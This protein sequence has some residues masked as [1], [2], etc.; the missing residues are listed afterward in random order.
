MVDNAIDD[1]LALL[2]ADMKQID[3]LQQKC[4][5]EAA[6][7]T[8]NKRI[9]RRLTYVF[10]GAAIGVGALLTFVPQLDFVSQELRAVWLNALG[11]VSMATGVGIA[12][13]EKYVD[14]DRQRQRA[15][16]L[17]THVAEMGNGESAAKAERSLLVHAKGATEPKAYE[18]VRAETA[19]RLLA[20]ER[21][22]LELGVG[23]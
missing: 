10:G 5:E 19:A 4:T 6:K 9:G 8:R 23:I 2:D 7:F 13:M 22:A 3:Q 1:I 16:D 21:R 11:I 17:L 15:L 18:K 20:Y 14:P 12:V